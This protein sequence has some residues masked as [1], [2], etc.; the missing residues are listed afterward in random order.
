M[1]KIEQVLDGTAPQITPTLFILGR[2]WRAVLRETDMTLTRFNE[3]IS[4]FVIEPGVT[5][6][7]EVDARRKLR[8]ALASPGVTLRTLLNGLRMLKATRITFT[9][10]V[11]FQDMPSVTV[12][13]TINFHHPLHNP[14]PSQTKH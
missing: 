1:N 6:R 14:D 2:L 13:D 7:Q 12:S 10:E 5:R 4:V 11:T 9:M 8:V 3:L